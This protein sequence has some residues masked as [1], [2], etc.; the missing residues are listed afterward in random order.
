[1]TVRVHEQNLPGIGRRYELEVGGGTRLVIVEERGGGRRIA[2]AQSSGEELWSEM[3]LDP[4]EAATVGAL[5]LGARFAV[6]Q[7]DVDSGTTP[8][9]E[10]DPC[11]VVI[12][13]VTVHDGSPAVGRLASDLPLDGS[14]V[15][16]VISDSSPALVH[17]PDDRP[18]RA[19]DKLVVAARA[20]EMSAVIRRLRALDPR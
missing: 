13:T 3:A 6:E 4:D 14:V 20:G 18:A 10:E 12:E 9:A 5:L 2:A 11:G 7:D 8:T 17:D 16:A 1:M 15:L 19:G